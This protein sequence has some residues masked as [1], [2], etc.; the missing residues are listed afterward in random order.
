MKAAFSNASP[1]YM[2]PSS[3]NSSRSEVFLKEEVKKTFQMAPMCP[4][5]PP[6]AFS[7]HIYNEP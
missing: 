6:I 3:F 5:T 2:V 4:L 7:D 1:G